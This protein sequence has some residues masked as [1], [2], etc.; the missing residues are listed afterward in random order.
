M[1]SRNFAPRNTET[2]GF[3]ADIE[4]SADRRPAAGDRT[5]DAGSEGRTSCSGAVG[6]DWVGQDVHDGKCHSECGEADPH[7]QSQQDPGSPA[8]HGNEGVLPQQCGGVLCELLRLLSAGGLHPFHRYLHRERPRH[9][10]G[11]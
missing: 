11:T 9:Q 4:V 2:H 5:T 1:E 7:L 3:P 6:C 8:L 10:R